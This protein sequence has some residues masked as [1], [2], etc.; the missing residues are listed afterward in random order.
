MD[1]I[2]DMLE[3]PYKNGINNNN[4]SNSNDSKSPSTQDVRISLFFLAF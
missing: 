2:E 4:N 3:A 1:D